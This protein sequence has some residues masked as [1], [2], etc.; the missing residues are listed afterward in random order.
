MRGGLLLLIT[1]GTSL[2]LA[3]VTDLNAYKGLVKP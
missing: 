2:H 1:Q 3:G